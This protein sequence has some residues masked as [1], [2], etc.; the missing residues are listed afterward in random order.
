MKRNLIVVG[1][2]IATLTVFGFSKTKPKQL[3]KN[4]PALRI[5]ISLPLTGSIAHLGESARRGIEFAYEERQKNNPKPGVEYFF[6]DNAFDAK[7]A[8]SAYQ[9]LKANGELAAIITASSPASLATHP[10]AKA[11]NL[12]Q[13]AI[14]ASVSEYSTPNDLS[15]R[16]HSRAE[17][18]VQAIIGYL[19]KHSVQ[20][21]G[22]IYINNDYGK[23]VFDALKKKLSSDKFAGTES[24]LPNE[25]DF[26]THLAKIKGSKPDVLLMVGAASH[27]VS[28][29][30]QSSGMDFKPNFLAS[31]SALDPETLKVAGDY[32]T[33]LVLPDMF[34]EESANQETK[35]FVDSFKQKYGLLPDMF[36][37]QGYEAARLTVSAL[38]KCGRNGECVKSYLFNLKDY[39]SILGNLAFDS[40]GD[41]DF[42]YF[43]KIFRNGKFERLE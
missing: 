15:F 4:E 14:F 38:E 35:A 29:L 23:S 7:T 18:E 13:M 20:R 16:V 37:A 24:F 3:Q 40:N 22:V 32:T 2:V 10:L 41:P 21:L 1:I 17:K 5:G 28:I 25:N 11:D 8:V 39:P 31:A 27:V 12:F 30:R 33:G 26:R 36:A 34:D 43:M 9:K 42:D 6:E 19:E